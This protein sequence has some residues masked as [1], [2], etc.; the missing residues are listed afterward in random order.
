MQ[1]AQ[2]QTRA[3]QPAPTGLGIGHVHLKV[4]DLDRSLAFYHGLLGLDIMQR[5]GDRAAFLSVG[6]YHHH[7]ALNT[8]SSAGGA[9]PPRNATGLYHTAF[10]YPSR[11][12]LSNAVRRMLDGGVVLQGSADHGVS[13]AVYLSDPD[14]NGVELYWDRPKAEWPVGQDGYLE[15]RNS[16]LD[17]P[18]LLALSDG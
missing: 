1:M 14:R 11:H 7:I 13:Q 4:A 18:E 15:M 3:T 8:W 17:V 5:Y 16:R 10:L 12:D 9:P 2:P 6:G